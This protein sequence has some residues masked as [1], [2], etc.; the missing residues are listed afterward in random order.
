MITLKKTSLVAVFASLA[1]VWAAPDV[2]AVHV[3]KT[4]AAIEPPTLTRDCLYFTLAGVTTAD[5]V[6]SQGPWFAVP[7]SH[8][9][10]DWIYVLLLTA[11]QKQLSNNFTV[12]TT[13]ASVCGGYAEVRD[14]A[15]VAPETRP[16]F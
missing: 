3:G 8:Q 16:A 5:G 4:V 13:G 11:K 1:A 7:H 6:V 14:I 2:A 10:Y 9:G 15:T 12:V